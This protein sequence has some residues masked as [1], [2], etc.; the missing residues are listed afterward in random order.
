MM[1]FHAFGGKEKAECLLLLMPQKCQN[2]SEAYTRGDLC[3]GSLMSAEHGLLRTEI[4]AYQK[5][6]CLPCIELF[7]ATCDV[8]HAFHCSLEHSALHAHCLL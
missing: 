7:Y 1:E 3:A 6:S 5:V 4:R 2:I 8:W